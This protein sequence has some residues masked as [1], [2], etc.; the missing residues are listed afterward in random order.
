MPEGTGLDTGGMQT[1]PGIFLPISHFSYSLYWPHSFRLAS[2]TWRPH[3]FLEALGLPLAAVRHR[4]LQLYAVS[5][6]KISGIS[7]DWFSQI[8]GPVCFP[9]FLCPTCNINPQPLSPQETRG[10]VLTLQKQKQEADSSAT[11]TAHG[12]GIKKLMDR[13][14]IACLETLAASSSVQSEGSGSRSEPVACVRQATHHR[15]VIS[16]FC[17]FS[18]LFSHPPGVSSVLSTLLF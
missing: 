1:P 10:W 17:S 15:H 4:K 14:G 12:R 18:I 6:S 8:A 9:P 11:D 3:R 2:S 7:S 16:T 5:N 13:P